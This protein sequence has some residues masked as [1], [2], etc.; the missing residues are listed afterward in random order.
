MRL[1]DLAQ[2]LF[3]LRPEWAGI[4]V[5]GVASDSRKVLPGYVFVA[6]AGSRDDGNRYAEAAMAAGAIL[7]LSSAPAPKAEWPWVKVADPRATLAQLAARFFA[8]QP[9]HIAAVTGT[10]GKTSVAEFTR[11]IFALSA[12]RAASLGT[13][14]VRAPGVDLYAGLTTPD[15][16]TLHQALAQLKKNGVEYA[17]MEASSHGIDQRRLDGVRIQAAA[18]LNLSRDHLDYHQTMEA[19]FAAKAELFTRLLPP[20]GVAVLN[21]DEEHF[22]ALTDICAARGHR[23]LRAGKAGVELRLLRA[24]PHAGGIHFSADILGRR[25][26]AD[27]PL[28]GPFQAANVLAA[29]GLALGCGLDG[30]D[31][32]RALPALQAVKGRMQKVGET[33]DGAAVYIDYAHKPGAL[34]TILTALRHHTRARLHVV[35]GCGGDRDQGKRPVMG[36]IAARLADCVYVTDDNPRSEDPAAIRAAIMAGSPGAQEYDD[37]ARAIA[38]ACEALGPGDV[39]VIAGKGHEQGQEIKGVVRP[40]DDVAEAQKVLRFKNGVTL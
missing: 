23:I 10:S 18:F 16:V 38:A 11:Q 29:A 25:V 3:D 15:A 21:A 37:R 26:D 5:N 9:D 33:A 2:G 35:F 28:V 12:K 1:A 34:E 31:V 13:L 17:A 30:A 4:K 39:L 24:E 27:L 40:F 20:G 32:A 19:Y 22:A 36:E 14:G 8:D 7:I 6:L